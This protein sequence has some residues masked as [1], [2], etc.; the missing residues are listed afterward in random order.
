MPDP[1]QLYDDMERLNALYEELCWGYHDELVFTHENGRVI[2]YNKTQEKNKWTITQNASMVGQQ[3][4]ESLQQWVH[5]PSVGKL[6]LGYGKCYCY[7]QQWL[8]DLFFG[9][10]LRK[11]LM[12]TMTDQVVVWCNQFMHRHPLDKQNRINYNEG[13]IRSFFNVPSFSCLICIRDSWCILCL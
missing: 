3:C 9:V 8:W 12:M 11:T 13:A 6:F 5:M 10:Y 4:L 1:N 2:I 7:Q